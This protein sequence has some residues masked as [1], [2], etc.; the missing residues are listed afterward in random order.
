MENRFER[1]EL[2]AWRRLSRGQEEEEKEEE[3]ERESGVLER[4]REKR[5]GVKRG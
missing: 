5:K 1:R 4:G 3:A 2:A